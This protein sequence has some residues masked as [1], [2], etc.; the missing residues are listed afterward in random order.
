MAPPSANHKINIVGL[1]NYRICRLCMVYLLE[2]TQ[3]LLMR[4]P[5]LIVTSSDV[6]LAYGVCKLR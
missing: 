6:R 3:I 5:A 2:N 4:F 1:P